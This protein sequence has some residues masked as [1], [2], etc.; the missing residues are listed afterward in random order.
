MK[1]V[2]LFLALVITG[3]AAVVSLGVGYV[4]YNADR[5]IADEL[6]GIG[7]KVLK[8]PVSI[9]AASF[10]LADGENRLTAVE[11][12]NPPGFGSGPAIEIPDVTWQTNP[13]FS[14]A[15]MTYIDRLII[16]GARV[17]LE[18]SGET[19]NLNL[20][21]S[22]V[23]AFAAKMSPPTHAIIVKEITLTN[24]TV[25]LRADSFGAAAKDIPL[26]DSRI[27]NVG[28]PDAPANHTDI[29]TALAQ[30]TMSS[31]ERA[32]RRLG[33]DTGL[34]IVGDGPPALRPQ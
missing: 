11:V 34:P 21:N 18:I 16:D 9:G 10:A 19:N 15:D 3:A 12:T 27:R 33:I 8:V 28:S 22:A 6:S 29:A 7:S 4:L 25:T 2:F 1:N 14:S 26:P 20:L 5:T 13:R 17:T 31:V 24:G 23:G 32:T 30:L